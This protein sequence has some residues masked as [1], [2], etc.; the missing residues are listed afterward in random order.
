MFPKITASPSHIPLSEDNAQSRQ[1]F[2]DI[3]RLLKLLNVYRTVIAALFV[4]LPLVGYELKSLG[5]GTP[6]MFLAISLAYLIFSI[7]STVSIHWRWPRFS[8]QVYGQVLVDIAA[9]TLLMHA[10]GGV[11]SG[12]GM[13]LLV[14][15]AGGS[16]LMPG[17]ITAIF[18][19]AAATLAVLA[20]QVRTHLF[21]P[22]PETTYTQAGLL[23]VAFFATAILTHT[24]AA[25]IRASETLAVQRG[26]DLANMQQLTEY[27]IQRMQTGVLVVDPQEK[28]RLINE[29]ARHLLGA[30]DFSMNQTIEQLCP[31]LAVQWR[32]WCEDQ[33]TEPQ[34]LRSP[35]SVAVLLPRFAH[36]GNDNSSGTLIFLEDTAALAQQAQQMK[37]AS[38]G[39]LTASIA[40]EI[41]NPL[42]AISHAGQLLAESPGRD[43]G[44]TRFIQ[45]IGEQARRVNTII[46]NILQLSRRERSHPQNFPLKEW[47]EH[48][49]DEFCRTQNV[50]P[51]SIAVEVKPS[52]LQVRIDPSQLHQIVWNLCDN[53]LRHSV[54][55]KRA[56]GAPDIHLHGGITPKSTHP[57]LDVINEGSVIASEVVEHIFEPFFTTAP[58]GTGL[59]LY[60]CRELCECNQARLSYFV[61]KNDSN[62][63]RI[64]FADPRRKQVA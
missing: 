31:V 61:V 60:I 1:G 49:A 57:F 35:Q 23:G 32:I 24:L 33:Q 26:T 20:E 10:S 27:I 22:S 12:L 53:A 2:S 34:A 7:L 13:L 55:G 40:H 62:C 42:G 52:D 39:R 18:F 36:M 44:D 3:W 30:Q 4:M 46:E 14:S 56:F 11:E 41:R 48:F 47:L 29:S 43:A 51:G 5:S 21:G 58:Q 59:G 63:F 8:V 45:I 28:V 15:V 9:I 54:K 16:M 37:L 6:E 19:A 50:D 38:L 17:R 64:T 25:R